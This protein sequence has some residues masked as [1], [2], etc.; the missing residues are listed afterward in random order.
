MYRRLRP[1]ASSS[2]VSIWSAASGLSDAPR[3]A[4][5]QAIIKVITSAATAPPIRTLQL[6]EPPRHDIMATSSVISPDPCD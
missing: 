1:I 2:R 4:P 3:G 5:V 6:K